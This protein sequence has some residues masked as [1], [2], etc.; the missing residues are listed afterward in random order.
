MVRAD[1]REVRERGT[2]DEIALTRSTTEGMNIFMHGLDW[3]AGDEVVY[4]K[5]E[6]G[7]GIQP[8]RRRSSALGIKP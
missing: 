4:C 1:G 2:A 8:Y 3:K 6:H 7:G 5:H